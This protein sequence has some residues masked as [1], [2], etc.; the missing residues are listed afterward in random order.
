MEE[1]RSQLRPLFGVEHG[2]EPLRVELV[3]WRLGQLVLPLDAQPL[4][5]LTRLQQVLWLQE[6]N[7]I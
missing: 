6:K 3:V 1:F 5:I 2:G 4:Q 7:S